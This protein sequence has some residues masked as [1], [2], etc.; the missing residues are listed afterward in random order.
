[1]EESILQSEAKPFLRWAGG[2]GWAVRHV[3]NIVRNLDYNNYHEPFLGGGAMFFALQPNVAFLSDVNPR[4]VQ[5][6][7]TLKENQ[8]SVITALL[9]F[10]IG[11]EDYYTIRRTKFEHE[12]ERAAQFIYLN[13]LCFNGLYRVNRKGEFNVPYGNRESHNFN[14]PNLRAV[15]QSLK[16]TEIYHRDFEASLVDVSPGDL[17]FLDPPYTVSH[18]T[19]GFIEY[20]EK[21]FSMADQERLSKFIAE[22]ARR[23]AYF[24]LTNAAHETIRDMF[25]S[26]GD[27]YEFS[28]PS[29]IAARNANRGRYAELFITNI[30]N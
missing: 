26:L 28:R 17:V 2:K 23:N 15:A 19:N 12:F 4:L 6:Y 20:N 29:L 13:Q 18:N 21:L 30:Q 5:T 3:L 14:L 10:P 9:N 22:V 16:N 27:I 24:I 25:G 8:E 11:K 7:R 1:M